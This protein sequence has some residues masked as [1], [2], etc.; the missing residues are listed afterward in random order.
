[1]DAKGW[2]YWSIVEKYTDEVIRIR[3]DFHMNPEL[4]NEE[5]RTSGIVAGVMEERGLE[6]KRGIAGTGVVGLLEGGEEGRVV[7]LR[8]DMDALPIQDL[9]DA[10]Y[11]SRCAGKMHACGHDAHMAVLLG[12]A[13]VLTELRRKLKGK[14]KFIFQPAEETTGG[15]KRMVEEGVL[16]NPKVDAV[17]GLHVSP[18]IQTGW[19]GIRYGVA[20]ACS[21][22]FG[23]LIKG[24]AAHGANPEKGTD[25]IAIAAQ[26]INAYQYI[27]SRQ[28]DPLKPGVL[29]IG[30]I[31]GGTQANII[32]DEV[33][34][35]GT[36]RTL[37][38]NVRETIIERMESIAKNLCRGMGGDCEFLVIPGYPSLVNDDHMVKVVETA[39]R[40]VVGNNLLYID[41]PRLGV[42][43]FAYYLQKVPGAFWRLGTGNKKK[44]IECI[45]HNPYFDID[46]DALAVGVAINTQI[47]LDFLA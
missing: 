22:A 40:K 13:M 16:D 42:E 34:L 7:A 35:T 44:G 33:K 3:R 19:P 11:S 41:S 47:V 14:V 39:A 46:E 28:I 21:D 36:I 18:E 45:P 4:G 37:H 29:T 9:K 26:L 31:S 5:V 30:T 12:T 20:N 15:A 24:K 27:V 8:A 1:M 17:F 38:E 6:V 25:A 2:E 43:D 32:A 10:E 23:V